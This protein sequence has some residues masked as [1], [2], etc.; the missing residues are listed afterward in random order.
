M[1]AQTPASPGARQRLPQPSPGSIGAPAQAR[2]DRA[3]A[4]RDGVDGGR[5][6]VLIQSQAAPQISESLKEFDCFAGDLRCIVNRFH[7]V[8]GNP[9]RP[10]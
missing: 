8:G 6:E 1:R 4:A 7:F 5:R 2:P 9:P 3:R 10:S